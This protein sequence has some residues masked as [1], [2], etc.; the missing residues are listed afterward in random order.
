MNKRDNIPE[1]NISNFFTLVTMPA[2]IHIK[3]RFPNISTSSHASITE[4]SPG[5][6]FANAAMASPSSSE[7]TPVTESS[8]LFAMT[9]S[10]PSSQHKKSKADKYT[11]PMEEG[12]K[13]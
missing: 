7:V 11:F 8:T 10:T 2:R 6:V 5:T 1:S 13:Y 9:A 3:S 12:R 4:C